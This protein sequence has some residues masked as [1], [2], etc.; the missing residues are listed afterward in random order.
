MPTSIQ[1]GIRHLLG[2]T[3]VVAVVMAAIGPVVRAWDTERR[4]ALAVYAAVPLL[5]LAA[6]VCVLC[7]Y[8]VRVERDAGEIL[9]QVRTS[10]SPETRAALAALLSICVTVHGSRTARALF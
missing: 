4:I 9:L 7:M 1:Y 3:L 6:Y 8:R 10:D 5:L 2:L